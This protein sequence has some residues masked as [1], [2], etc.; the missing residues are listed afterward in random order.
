MYVF[1][2]RGVALHL[3]V[4]PSFLI[5]AVAASITKLKVPIANAYAAIDTIIFPT[6]CEIVLEHKSHLSVNAPIC[7]QYERGHKRCDDHKGQSI[8]DVLV[9]LSL[10]HDQRRRHDRI[11]CVKI[12]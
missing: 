10:G 9:P 7:P 4:A 11:F 3:P 1:I 8:I 12:C 5:G 6:W 2:L